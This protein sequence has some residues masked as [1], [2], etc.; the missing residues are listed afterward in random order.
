MALKIKAN[1]LIEHCYLQIFGSGVE[2]RRTAFTG[3]A[4]HFPFGQVDAIL[5]DANNV[6][7][8]QVGEEVFSLQT[9]PSNAKHRE[10]IGIFLQEVRRAHGAA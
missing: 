6:L 3:G 10:V 7:S 4:R 1:S 5:M 2:Y 8:F 9:K